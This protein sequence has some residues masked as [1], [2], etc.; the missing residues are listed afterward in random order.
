MSDGSYSEM[1]MFDLFRMEAEGQVASLG[2]GLLDLENNPQDSTLLEPLMRAAHSLKGAARMVGVD[3]VVQLSHVMEDVFVSAQHEKI[4]LNRAGINS[5]LRATDLI[6]TITALNESELTEW[7]T[8][9]KVEIDKASNA[10]SL[11]NAGEIC[12]E[13]SIT[14]DIV[15]PGETAEIVEVN[16]GEEAA[17]RSSDVVQ[18]VD[19]KAAL[20]S[21]PGNK[22]DDRTLRVNADKMSRILGVSGEILVESRRLSLFSDALMQLKVRQNELME[23]IE[24]ILYREGVDFSQS[25]EDQLRRAQQT[26]ND[27]RQMLG[28]QLSLFDEYGRRNSNLSSKLYHEV[29]GSRMQPFSAGTVGLSRMVRD[30]SHSL[31]KEVALKIRGEDTPVDRDVLDKI[32]AP[33]N[34][35]LRNSVDHGIETPQQRLAA[36]KSSRAEVVVA[37]SHGGGLLRISIRDDGRGIDTE[38]LKQKI[39]EKGLTTSEVVGSLSENELIEFLF[40]P[41]FSTRDEVTETSGRGVGL[42]VVHDMMRELGGT[43]SVE[44]DFGKG[45]KF[46]LQLPLSLSVLTALLV[47]ISG[48]PYAFPLSRVDRVL[49]ILND[50][51]QIME[52]RQYCDLDGELIGLAA[53]S[54]V[55]GFEDVSS[56]SDTVSVVV[57]SDRLACYGVVVDRFIG[58]RQLSVQSLDPRLGKVQ[59]ISA[60]ALMEDGSPLLILDVDDVVRSIVNIVEG[61]R[62]T[63]VLYDGQQEQRLKAKRVLIVEDS[64][65]VREVERNLL[66][67]YGYIVD[68]A[69]DG[70]DGWNTIRGSIHSGGYQLVISDVDMPRMN[71]IELV[72]NIKQDPQFSAVP[73][74]IISY[75]DRAEDRRRGL[76]AGADYYLAKGSI[77][78]DTLIDAVVDLI[79]VAQ[80]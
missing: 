40:L 57:V 68:T 69:V 70:M 4:I 50:D 3:A 64:L 37:A 66:E 43:V 76:D 32:K 80:P 5:L 30:L 74:M 61:G 45:V 17:P 31:G 72:Q 6:E 19:A 49:S 24:S 48:E 16:H 53:G 11:I 42:D 58:Q 18:P 1:S 10:L 14:Q 29:T 56:S 46:I 47:D 63:S 2:K 26:L 20:N 25:L 79:G 62:L 73:V 13:S 59:D 36:G 65:T 22:V 15:G 75:K 39:V 27:C 67:A 78:D 51:I 21:M 44:N 71:G 52:G 7:F 77:H 54:Q 12:E 55:L 35:L 28:E 23:N 34:H 33:L 60:T 9:N 38:G 8:T 41:D